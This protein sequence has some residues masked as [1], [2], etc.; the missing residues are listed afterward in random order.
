[1]DHILIVQCG[2]RNCAP[3]Q[4][5]RLK[6]RIGRHFTGSSDRTENIF[7]GGLHLL[8]WKF[9]RDGPTRDFNGKTKLL[10][11]GKIIDFND[12]TIDIIGQLVS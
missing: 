4:L 3:G 8:S 10:L 9:I 1:M 7:D 11:D 6:C 2:K 5:N 12:H